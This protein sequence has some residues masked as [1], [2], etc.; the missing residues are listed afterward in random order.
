VYYTTRDV[1]PARVMKVAITG[2]EATPVGPPAA[3]D[4][5]V[6]PDGASLMLI[7][8]EGQGAAR[9]TSLALL[10]L[11]DGAILQR[12]P[13][14]AGMRADWTW[15]PDGKGF[16]YGLLRQQN[17]DLWL[18]TLDSA[19][20][21]QITHLTTPNDFIVGFAYS[22]DGKQLAVIHGIETQ[23]VVLFTKFRK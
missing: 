7:V 14:P 3:Y 12:W 13:A 2:G 10:R 17:A 4:P 15:L 16:V 23:D 18:Q 22:P 11:A 9:K 5:V 20:P 6:A 8:S 19:P 21:R 1:S